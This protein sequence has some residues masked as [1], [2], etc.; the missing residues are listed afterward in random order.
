MGVHAPGSRES[1][2]QSFD[3]TDAA[4]IKGHHELAQRLMFLAIFNAKFLAVLFQRGG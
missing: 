3:A 4:V 2:G 1:L